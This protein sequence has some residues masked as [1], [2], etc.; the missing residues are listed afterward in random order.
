LVIVPELLTLVV[1]RV[2][3]LAIALLLLRMRL[4]V[5]PTPPDN[6]NNEPPLALL[7][8][9]VVPPLFT[10]SAPLTVRA[11]L[12]LFSVM[13]VTFDPTAALIVVNPVPAPE[14]VIVPALLTGLV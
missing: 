8:V 14:L 2:M 13:P 3:P 10:V 11:E 9:R 1:E 12:A 7:F 5:P 6:V 4:P